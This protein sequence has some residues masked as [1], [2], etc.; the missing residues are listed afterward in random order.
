MSKITPQ[1]LKSI[2]QFRK[3]NPQY[4][5]YTNEA[6][7]SIMQSEMK[8]TGKIYPGF[9]SLENSDKIM[10]TQ[11]Q[12]AFN[13]GFSSN[14]LA[15][16][17][18]TT[19]VLEP[20]YSP[21]EKQAV[22]FLHGMVK[23]AD[24][25][26]FAQYKKDGVLGKSINFVK[27][28]FNTEFAKSN[29]ENSIRETK[30]DIM[31]L[32]SAASGKLDTTDWL[33]NIKEV[34]FV[35]T[36]KKQ[37]GVEFNEENIKDCSEKAKKMA[38]FQGAADVI[39]S[40]KTKLSSA[41]ESDPGKIV[42]RAGEKAIINTLSALGY[43][44][45]GD[46]IKEA[47]KGHENDPVIKNYMKENGRFAV[48]K[49]KNGQVG[50]YRE[51]ENGFHPITPEMA[52]IIGEEVELRLNKVYAGILGV[53][54]S[55]NMSNEEIDKL[56]AEK[57]EAYQKDYEASFAKAYGK[58]DLK[59]LSQNYMISQDKGKAYVQMGVNI[60]AIAGA[61]FSGG[62][63]LALASTAVLVTNPIDLIERST[64]AD[65][66]TKEDWSEYG[67]Q[68]LEQ[69]GWMALGI[70][71][72]KI[73]DMTRSFVKV[74]GLS[75]VVKS[76]GKSFD[77]FM[78]IA[79][80][81]PDIPL[82]IA[83]SLK[84]VNTMA[85]VLGV[86]AETAADITATA[87]LQKDG[88]TAV[89]WISSLGGAIVGTKIQKVIA[90]M[91]HDAKISYLMTAFKD[92]K[93]T[94]N[95]AVQLLKT[96][97]NVPYGTKKL[98][99]DVNPI[100]SDIKTIKEIL[101]ANENLISENEFL[102]LLNDNN[103]AAAK[104]LLQNQ[105]VIKGFDPYQITCIL[106]N[107]NKENKHIAE[108]LF[109]EVNLNSV[110][111]VQGYMFNSIAILES[112]YTNEP[113]IKDAIINKKTDIDNIK[114]I[115]FEL[116]D[117]NIEFANKLYQVEDFPNDYIPYV[118]SSLKH[119]SDVYD[120]M[121]FA[122]KLCFDK[123]FPKDPIAN[124]LRS[125]NKDNIILAEK[126]CDDT[127][128][129][130]DEI[131]AV[132]TN[133]NAKNSD[134]AEILYS[135]FPKDKCL[136]FMKDRNLMETV[137]LLKECDFNDCNNI[138]LKNRKLLLNSLLE[139][140]DKVYDILASMG[141]KL[142]SIKSRL[143]V[144][145]GGKLNVL[146]TDKTNRLKFVKT[147]MAN[148]NPKIE[149]IFKKIDFSQYE[150][151][152]PLKYP[153]ED[154]LKNIQNLITNLSGKE[155]DIILKHFGIQKNTN[156]FDGLINN[157]SADN[158]KV[159][160]AGK[161]IAEKVRLEIEEFTM[162]NEV[163]I[164]DKQV[165]EVLDDIISGFPEFT[166]I[167][168]KK[169]HNTHKYTLDIH[170]M[171][172]L[173]SVIN[174]PEYKMLSDAD[175]T[176]LKMAAIMHDIAKKGKYIDKGHELTSAN[177]SRY[178]LEQYKLSENT[179]SRILDLISNHSWFADYNLNRIT[180]DDAAVKLRHPGDFKMCKIL[181][182]SDLKNVN[183]DFHLN[184]SGTR[185][186]EEFDKFIDTKMKA[187][188]E[189]LNTYIYSQSNIVF[190][191]QFICNGEKFPKQTITVNNKNLQLKVL[192]LS[193]ESINSDL[194][195]YGFPPGVTKENARFN[196]HMSE[197]SINYMYDIMYLLGNRENKSTLSSSL[198]S[199][200]NNK[201]YMERQYGF[202]LDV[203]KTDIAAASKQNFRSGTSKTESAFKSLLLFNEAA[204]KAKYSE[205]DRTFTKDNLLKVLEDKNI[206]LSDKEYIEL[207]LYLS[208]KKYLSQINDVKINDKI[209]TKDDLTDAIRISTDK[210]LAD[211][212]N[213]EIVSINPKIKG[214]IAKVKSLE[215]CPAEFLEFAAKF[216]LPI[217]LMKK[218]D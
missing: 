195:T 87:L 16:P 116:N 147:L 75:Q 126:L 160:Y 181:S 89:D 127:K 97:D 24:E 62:G 175:K 170:I 83:S 162:N 154:F 191:S 27:E 26:M 139:M 80:K 215:E 66:M 213:S 94:E 2:D 99:A 114:D 153:R 199:V 151:G 179:R 4:S 185:N 129:P 14:Y 39:K 70:G 211:E 46:V 10:E 137:K 169:Q 192:N 58:K 59:S 177:Y 52:R 84:K 92:I 210:L 194:S 142:E 90:P 41:L 184:I 132:L 201:T 37:R 164:K 120:I 157:V 47:I 138:S 121:Q 161:E 150:N 115:I 206:K 207:T 7:I 217:I 40:I 144:S 9:E 152:L 125:V 204:I 182:K 6:L 102:S 156:D 208:D 173:Q 196:V 22:E 166:F 148:N 159:S 130:K 85:N 107:I 18:W 197:P 17:D 77:D 101:N 105:N 133:I 141:Y 50:I 36:F 13:T 205:L 202:I 214:L 88:A 63:S 118:L 190:D 186:A 203:D 79:A 56:T 200:E 122:E 8:K 48:K 86:S 112:K 188:E 72:G 60:L 113:V 25:N 68:S 32:E 123:K 135:L 103:T 218:T 134:F 73:G 149:R 43:T 1:Q 20:K 31:A 176:V 174:D 128:F 15:I 158:L 104:M 74:K 28:V 212:S 172:V 193:D 108:Y 98:S 216:D 145:I 100:E 136:G 117:N 49:D 78:K 33:G 178:L 21:A 53:D 209:I 23:I 124:I 76:S 81:S 198:V 29:V 12:S 119:K 163:L 3:S 38:E 110:D 69:I 140:D 146:T 167:I 143:K 171:K 65:G 55:A 45:I 82:D 180:A 106:S 11:P 51:T 42:G 109:S 183:D 95:E 54:V 61:M 91:S 19:R 5:L 64:D 111:D 187:V 44:K 131:G 30:E 57:F 93:L 96:I 34:T 189:S 165:K 35:Q 67:K 71:A 168:G 155:Q